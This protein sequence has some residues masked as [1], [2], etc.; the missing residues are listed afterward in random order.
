M[1]IKVDYREILRLQSIGHNISQIAGSLHSSRNTVREVERLAD[2]KRI[3]W[4]LG[5]E[6]TNPQLYICFIRNG[7]KKQTFIWNRI[8]LG[9]TVNWR[10]GGSIPFE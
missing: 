5:E 9:F 7:R 2:E 8:V 3:R 6:M 10:K 1:M 4:P